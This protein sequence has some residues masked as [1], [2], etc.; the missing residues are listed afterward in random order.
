MRKSIAR[1]VKLLS[2]VAL[3]LAGVVPLGGCYPRSQVY[4]VGN[5][6]GLVFNVNPPEAEVILDGVAQGPASAFTEDRY[7]K[8][9]PG[10][11]VLELR[12]PGYETYTREFYMANSLLRIE[13]GLIRK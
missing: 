12:L 11:H 6:A 2:L 13:E 5:E 10:K 8:V 1:A 4:G 9:S 3:L 7:L